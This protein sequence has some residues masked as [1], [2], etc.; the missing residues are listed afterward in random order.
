M[1]KLYRLAAGSVIAAT[2]AL[3]GASMAL[4]DGM[5]PRGKVAFERPA[6]W[7]GFYFGVSSGYAFT[8]FDNTYV[9]GGGTWSGSE[10]ASI[11]GAHIGI[12]HQFGLI[13]LGLEGNFTSAIRDDFSS[14]GCPNPATTCHARFNDVLSVGP[15]I[16]WAAG[17][18]M[19]YL[20][21]GYASTRFSDNVRIRA[22]PPV[23]TVVGAGERHDG[24]YIGLGAEYVIS[25]GWTAGLEYRHYDFGDE[26]Y[27]RHTPAG[28]PVPG[29]TATVGVGLDTITAR[30]RW[31]WG[32]TEPVK[33]MK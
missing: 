13:V 21:L 26:V 15:R 14:T 11:V 17:H 30:V 18:W 29:D 16:G 8:D 9:A 7:S 22:E 23:I 24:F 2:A 12:Q 20:T 25:P 10:D 28:A 33:P 4:A 19:P 3:G 32:R 27:L 6:D 5:A 31:R 1:R